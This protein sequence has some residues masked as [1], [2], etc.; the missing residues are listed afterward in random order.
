M[1]SRS[2]RFIDMLVDMEDAAGEA[3]EPMTNGNAHGEAPTMNDL[4]PAA[5]EEVR[6]VHHCLS[7]LLRHYWRCH[8]LTTPE[9]REK[10]RRMVDSL[11]RFEKGVI[12]ECGAK[13]G[14]F[15]VSHSATAPTPRLCHPHGCSSVFVV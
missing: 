11:L 15:S 2:D 6:T 3:D 8:P 13:Y 9:L 14:E 12:D 1:I 7:E 4:S 10:A 5:M